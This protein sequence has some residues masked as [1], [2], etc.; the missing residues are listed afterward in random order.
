MTDPHWKSP[1]PAEV[2]EVLIAAHPRAASL[3]LGRE[4]SGPLRLHL[5]NPRPL[6]AL[7]EAIDAWEV[8]IVDRNA[9][10]GAQL[11]FARYRVEFWDEDNPID[12]LLCDSYD[13]SA[14]G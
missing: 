5:V 2:A 9:E 4:P 1:Y 10:E 8:R 13:V 6:K 12:N 7:V 3:T 14:V 11:E